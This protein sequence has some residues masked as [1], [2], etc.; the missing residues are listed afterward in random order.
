[1]TSDLTTLLTELTKV[2]RLTGIYDN[3]RFQEAKKD[4]DSADLRFIYKTEKISRK[5]VELRAFWRTKI[6][7]YI[8]EQL[9]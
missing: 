1:M 4:I 6:D 3:L 2:N 7:E 9:G 5:N 8:K